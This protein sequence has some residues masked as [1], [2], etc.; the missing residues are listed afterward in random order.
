[1]LKVDVV[2]LNPQ[3]K[4]AVKNKLGLS[5]PPLN[6][7]YLAASLEKASFSVKIIDDDLK[8][9]GSERIANIIEKLNP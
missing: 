7:M 4:T 1:M 9:W 3:D 8:R 5:L 6:L 2:L